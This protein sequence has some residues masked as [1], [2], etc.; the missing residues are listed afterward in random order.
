MKNRLWFILTIII[1]L[2]VATPAFAQTAEA[3]EEETMSPGEESTGTDTTTTTTSTT[4]TTTTVDSSSASPMLWKDAGGMVYANSAQKFSLSAKDDQSNIDFTEYRIDNGNF[5]KYHGPITIQ[6]EG[7]HTLVYRSVDKA[8]NVEVDRVYNVVIDNS[9]PEVQIIPAKP[10]VKVEGRVFTSPGNA[11]TIRAT[12]TH[13]GVK[14]VKYSVN[15]SEMK[16]YKNNDT[17]QL[18]EQGNQLIQYEAS[19]NLGN[20]SNGGASLLVNVDGEKPKIEIKPTAPLMQVGEKKYARRTTGFNVSASDTGSGVDLIL[21]RIDG[22]QNWQT[23]ADTIFFDDEKAHSI[24]AKAIDIVGNE[25][26]AVKSEFL[27][28]DN[29]PTTELTPVQ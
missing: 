15:E 7:P 19:D 8:G 25:S 29:P 10:F 6:A 1:S 3:A 28:D 9:K 17:V 22:N 2:A 27:V 14:E 26:E 24:E 11:F 12:D 23:Y 21:V 4:T 5:Q 16:A 13:S 18:T 20:K